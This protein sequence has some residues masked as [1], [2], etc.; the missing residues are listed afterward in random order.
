MRLSWFCR[1]ASPPNTVGFR[2]LARLLFHLSM[3]AALA[4]NLPHR[5]R[6]HEFSAGRLGFSLKINFFFRCEAEFLDGH[7]MS[8]T[9]L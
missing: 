5:S 1:Q 3:V 7:L 4:E 2:Q 6:E 8:S 9:R